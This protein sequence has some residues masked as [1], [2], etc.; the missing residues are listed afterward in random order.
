M[1]CILAA[2]IL[3]SCG[4]TSAPAEITIKAVTGALSAEHLTPAT[5]TPE[6]GQIGSSNQPIL[7]HGVV[8]GEMST[9]RV[10]TQPT[11]DLRWTSKDRVPGASTSAPLDQWQVTLNFYF[12]GKGSIEAQGERLIPAAASGATY[13]MPA[14]HSTQYLAVIGGT[15]QYKY[16]RG[17]LATTP[18]ANGTYTQTFTLIDR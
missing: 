1:A 5:A 3:A 8:V 12:T 13:T 17:Q 2:S 18:N 6:V 16:V 11:K 10:L 4:S 7:E 15:G 14:A 9:T